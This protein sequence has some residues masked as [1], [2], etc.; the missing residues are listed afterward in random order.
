MMNFVLLKNQHFV[1]LWVG[2]TISLFGSLVSR[3]ALPFLVI[4]TLHATANQVALLR[5]CELVP[6][7]IVGL[8]AGVWVD[9]LK[10]RQVMIV[11]DV[12]RAL[13]V[14]SIPVF[15]VLGHFH[16]IWMQIFL[17]AI[18]VSVF[19]VSF[20]SAYG[21]YIP[22]LVDDDQI[23]DANGKLAASAAVSEV[24]GFGLSGALFEWLGGALTLSVDAVSFL[25]SAFALLSIHKPEPRS[26]QGGH[27]PL[28]RELVGGLQYVWTNKTL[29]L[30][31][32]V[33]GIQNIFYG[34][35][36]TVYILYI[37]RA[38]HVSPGIQGVLYAVG[39]IGAF[40]TSA[41]SNA[42]FKRIEFG[43][44]F[45]FVSIMGVI[46]SA[47]L[48][49]A[50]GPM[51]LLIAFILAQQLIGDG[52]DTVFEIGVASFCQSQTDNDFLG[53]VNSIWEVISSICLLTGTILGGELATVIGLKNTLFAAICIRIVGLGLTS[54]SR[55]RKVVSVD[56]DTE[57]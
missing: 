18:V 13:L 25:F 41:L 48:P 8:L 30:L 20:D 54:F 23:T 52:A 9:R 56:A 47:F 34:I 40:A 50:S 16:W 21:A 53:R 37:S 24:A 15:L 1:K 35:S 3:L 49:F 6:G 5:V 43:K 36:G 29:T 45:V 46:G 27:V 10:R 51:W 44:L 32:G 42:L 4:Y 19:T 22:T 11:S 31:A 26:R 12:I 39:G 17:V 7:I 38:L 28:R 33:A 55:L 2:Q 57:H 14:G